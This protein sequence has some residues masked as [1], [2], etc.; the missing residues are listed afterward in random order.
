MVVVYGEEM[1]DQ[2]E[3]LEEEDWK[4]RS[5]FANRGRWIHEGH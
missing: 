4:D 3:A 1:L 2:L 5:T